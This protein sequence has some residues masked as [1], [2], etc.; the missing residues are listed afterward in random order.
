MIK[1]FDFLQKI[2]SIEKKEK[3]L[4]KEGPS[5]KKITDRH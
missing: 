5:I 1:A 2:L 4:S 3:R